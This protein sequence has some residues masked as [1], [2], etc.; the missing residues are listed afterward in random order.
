MKYTEQYTSSIIDFQKAAEKGVSVVADIIGRVGP[1]APGSEEELISEN[2]LADEICHY[3]D[4]IETEPFTV[5]RQAFM[6]F[7]PF[8]VIM[9]VASVFVNWFWSPLVAFIFCV[10][11]FVP[12]YFEFVRYME[13][14]DFLFPKQTSHNTFAVIPPKGKASQRVVVVTHADSQ[15]EWTLNWLMSQVPF[16]GEKGGFVT[17]VVIQIPA[18]I[19][20]MI[21]CIFALICWIAAKGAPANVLS[22][23]KFYVVMYIICIIFIP[24]ELCYIF[25]Q[26]HTKSVPGASDNLSGCAVNL[27][28]VR[29]MKD[30]GIELDRTEIVAVFS[31]S[32]EAG[33]RGAKAFA[34]KH[35]EEYQDMPTI[36]IALDTIRDLKDMAIY[37]R[38]LSGTLRHD[39]QVKELLRRSS[40]NCGR[41]LPYA[42]VYVGGTD[43]AAFTRLGYQACTIGAMD[44]GPAFYY[45]TREDSVENMR[46][47]CIATAIE[48][49]V[50][51][52][53]MYD[54]EGL[55]TI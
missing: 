23:T 35:Q 50:E 13:F 32:E 5:H 51:A 29:T 18:V 43:A 22:S 4:R 47:D 42:S 11:A 40:V 36:V 33:L 52:I 55:P 15:Y 7:I 34:K 27:E 6:G 24:L 3:A 45:H 25:F 37:D 49:M 1:R 14:N 10:L 38:D 17:K 20:L 26:S 9:G 12:L 30:A 48:L 21:Q 8:T 44:P 41:E 46:A 54:K 31:G 53:C 19:G 39:A 28:T 16:I 2:M